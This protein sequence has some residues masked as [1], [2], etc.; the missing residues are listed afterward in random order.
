MKE[1]TIHKSRSC[2]SLNEGTTQYIDPVCGMSVSGNRPEFHF[3]TD[4]VDYYFCSTHCLRTFKYDRKAGASGI[5][6]RSGRNLAL[7]VGL[8][9]GAALIAVFLAVIA[10]IAANGSVGFAISEIK[11]LWYWVLLLSAGFALQLGLFVHIRHL[12]SQ[13]LAGAKAELAASGTVSAGSM[14]ACC[15]HGLVTLL[16]FL[17]ISAAATFLARYQLSFL[18]VG[19]F[20]NLLGVTVMIGLAQKNHIEFKNP[21]LKA[22]SG[23]NMKMLQFFLVITGS[24]AVG[25]SFASS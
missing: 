19:L 13:R 8:S 22:I 21:V 17:G 24:V 18:I 2:C 25:V 20:S 6:S 15:S 5:R 4:G 7:P 23:L 11:R 9:G 16:P 10:V 3:A 1:N 14:I 12:V